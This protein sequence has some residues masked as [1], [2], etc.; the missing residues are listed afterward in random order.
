MDYVGCN[1]WLPQCHRHIII[2][3][4]VERVID[5]SFGAGEQ[6]ACF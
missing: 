2:G 5:V 4:D 6:A 3:E 1:C